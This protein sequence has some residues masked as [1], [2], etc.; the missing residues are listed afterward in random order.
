MYSFMSGSVVK[1][2]PAST[3]YMGSILGS[4]RS[5]G[6]GNGCPLQYSYLRNP[7]DRGAWQTTNNGVTELDITE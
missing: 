4:G 5:P 3:G 1:D 2:S 7:M 6:V